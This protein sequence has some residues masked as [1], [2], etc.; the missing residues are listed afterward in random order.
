VTLKKV[1]LNSS[2]AQRFKVRLPMGLSRLRIAMSINQA[3]AGYLGAFSR[4]IQFR[5]R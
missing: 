5:R 4:T 1:T 3:G 2:G